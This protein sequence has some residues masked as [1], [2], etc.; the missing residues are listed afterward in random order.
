MI[1]KI[2]ALLIASALLI[3]F[4]IAYAQDEE[5]VTVPDIVGLNVPQAAAE[6]NR[7]GLRLGAQTSFG[8]TADSGLAENSIS[9]QGITAGENVPFGTSVSIT[10]LRSDNALLIYDDND[11]T[12][13]NQSGGVMSL[14]SIAFN[15]VGGTNTASFSAA[16]WTG[17]LD[18][19]DCAQLW[20]VSRNGPKDVPE[21]TESTFWLTTNDT[22]QHFWTGTNGSTTFNVLQN[23]L[24]RA[25][26]TISVPGTCS[27]YLDSTS[28]GQSTGY[29]YVAYTTESWVIYNNSETDWMD[30]RQMTVSTNPDAV[31]GAIGGADASDNPER[32]V[33]ISSLLA[34]G[35]C[36]LGILEGTDSTPPVPCDPIYQFSTAQ[37]WWTVDLYFDSTFDGERRNCPAADPESLTVCIIPS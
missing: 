34:P 2:M 15:S 27:L 29:I 17:S 10:V 4:N 36:I 23:G 7:A 28:A 35:Q 13:V 20:S 6:L 25:T 32:V 14:G 30:F 9:D 37:P 26:C 1:R 11:I 22:S 5:T 21:C 18:I 12:L 24:E 3:I 31:G 19:G 33:A 8:W 16:R